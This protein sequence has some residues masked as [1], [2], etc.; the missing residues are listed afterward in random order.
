VRLHHNLYGD[1]EINMPHISLRDHDDVRLAAE[2]SLDLLDG[3]LGDVEV[4]DA[5]AQCNT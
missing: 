4:V 5:R 3:A 2:V 1:R